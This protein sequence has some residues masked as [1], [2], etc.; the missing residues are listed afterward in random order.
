MPH[1]LDLSKEL[2]KKIDEVL[3]RLKYSV[4]LSKV[5]DWL[6]NFEE[7]EVNKVLD[8]LRVF[9]YVSFNEF[10][11]RID[12][13][14]EK[15]FELVKSDEKIIIYPYGKLG[16]SGTLVTYPLRNTNVYERNEDRIELTHDLEK[17][18]FSKNYKHVIF[19]D[20]FIGSGK[21]FVE[22]FSK[23]FIQEWLKRNNIKNIYILASIIM[24]DGKKYILENYSQIEIFAEERHKI[25]NTEHSPLSIFNTVNELENICHKY[26]KVFKKFSKP[27]GYDNSQSLISFFHGTPNNTLPLIWGQTSEWKAIF[28]RYAN[29]RMDEAK[30]FKKSIAFYIGI[31]NRL[32]IDI[33]NDEIIFDEK[34]GK[35]VRIIKHNSKNDHSIIALVFLKNKNYDDLI[36]CHLL[37]LTISELNL[38]YH[39]AIQLNFIDKQKN[40][41]D[42]GRIFLERLNQKT[43]KENFRKESKENLSRVNI[44]YLPPMF[45]GK[46]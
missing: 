25:F 9:E 32:G 26:K 3:P 5:V 36:I 34:K 30:E 23:P 29:I 35:Y 31:C 28:P 1:T 17:I 21:T 10:I 37:G 15:I 40:L 22:E 4:L 16:K 43:K 8:F 12:D 41:T 19:L 42:S 20:D 24:V 44:L 13:L 33:F 39:N 6:E 11:Y 46:T 14:L 2:I 18:D 27:F 45:N 38:I 7:E